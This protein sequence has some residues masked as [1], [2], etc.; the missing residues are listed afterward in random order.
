MPVILPTVPPGSSTATTHARAGLARAS[1]ALETSA[2]RVAGG[3]AVALQALSDPGALVELSPAALDL[4][5]DLDGA[6]IDS[7]LAQHSYTAS[8]AVLQTADELG[9][10][11]LRIGQESD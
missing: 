11:L 7:R 6:L 8:A 10:E 2:E 3:T 4:L 5:D 1:Q 9:E